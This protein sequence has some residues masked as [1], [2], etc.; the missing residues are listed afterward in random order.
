[1]FIHSDVNTNDADIAS[2]PFVSSIRSA[3]SWIYS[4]KIYTL[5]FLVF[6]MFY[7]LMSKFIYVPIADILCVLNSKKVCEIGDEHIMRAHFV[8]LKLVKVSTIMT[9]IS[10]IIRILI[11]LIFVGVFSVNNMIYT[12]LT[13][14]SILFTII[15]SILMSIVYFVERKIGNVNSINFAVKL[16]MFFSNVIGMIFQIIYMCRILNQNLCTVFHIIML[17]VYCGC[18][19]YLLMNQ[20]YLSVILT[21]LNVI[22]SATVSF[23]LFWDYF[24]VNNYSKYAFNQCVLVMVF[25]SVVSIVLPLIMFFTSLYIISHSRIVDNISLKDSKKSN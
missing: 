13:T 1:M 9:L 7:N 11:I 2:N 19:N 24:I 22:F 18:I 16:S 25:F 15:Q 10:Y 14:I 5:C 6:L 8:C 12:L 4:Q 17:M 21:T 20:L 23:V 3:V